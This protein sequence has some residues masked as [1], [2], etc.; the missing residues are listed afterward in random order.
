MTKGIMGR[1]RLFHTLLL[2]TKC[3]TISDLSGPAGIGK[4]Q[5]FG[6]LI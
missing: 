4:V 3:C 1:K 2:S 6:P 5:N